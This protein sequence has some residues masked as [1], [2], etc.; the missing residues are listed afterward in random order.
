MIHV[1]E[2]FSLLPVELIL[3]KKKSVYSQIQ[4]YD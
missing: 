1:L 3:E 4:K 2:N